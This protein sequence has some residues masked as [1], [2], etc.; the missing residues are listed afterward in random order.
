[1][2]KSFWA[3]T[4]FPYYEMPFAL[5]PRIGFSVTRAFPDARLAA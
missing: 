4:S 1:M 2:G 5:K 3:F